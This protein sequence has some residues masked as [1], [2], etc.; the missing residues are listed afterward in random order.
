MGRLFLTDLPADVVEKLKP[1]S[2]HQFDLLSID[3]NRM[4]DEDARA[5]LPNNR[6]QAISGAMQAM[7]RNVEI[8]VEE[9]L[10]FLAS[11]LTVS[12]AVLLQGDIDRHDTEAVNHILGIAKDILDKHRVDVSEAFTRLHVAD[13]RKK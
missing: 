13:T 6:T 7:R 12:R 1:L 11:V 2:H 3:A 10:Y 4:K 5:K 9:P 8:D